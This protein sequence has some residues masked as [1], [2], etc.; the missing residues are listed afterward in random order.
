MEITS[1]KQS[2]IDKLIEKGY[3]KEQVEG[4]IAALQE[5]DLAR[6]V[7]ELTTAIIAIVATDVA[8]DLLL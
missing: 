5:T 2:V 1:K 4:F 6:Q 7:N 3:S 8:S